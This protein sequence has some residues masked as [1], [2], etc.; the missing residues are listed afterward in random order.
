MTLHHY[1]AEKAGTSLR[2]PPVRDAPLLTAH[3]DLLYL[4]LKMLSCILY[5]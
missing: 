1:L 5:Q 2:P 4:P 3:I